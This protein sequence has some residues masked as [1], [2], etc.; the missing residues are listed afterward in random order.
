MEAMSKDEFELEEG[1]KMARKINY[2]G[3]LG[4]EAREG[5]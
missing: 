2:T 5:V 4:E 3:N 1:M